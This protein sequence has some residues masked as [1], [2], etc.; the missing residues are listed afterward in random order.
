MLPWESLLNQCRV[1][2]CRGWRC[3]IA[4]LAGV[5]AA[6]TPFGDIVHAAQ[7]KA[8]ILHDKT[9]ALLKSG[10]VELSGDDAVSFLIGNSVTIKKTDVPRRFQASEFD[11]YFYFIDGHTAYQCVA[12][13]CSTAFWKV[14]G[15]EIC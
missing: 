6:A 4:L 13:D 1:N 3:A 12:N 5:L 2:Q 10:Y 9:K 11:R 15:K 8:G 7:K 14:D